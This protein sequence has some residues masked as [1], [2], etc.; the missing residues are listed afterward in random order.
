MLSRPTNWFAGQ[1]QL[2]PAADIPPPVPSESHPK[3]LG[4]ILFAPRLSKNSIPARGSLFCRIPWHHRQI[5]VPHAAGITSLLRVQHKKR[6]KIQNCKPH[7]TPPPL[8]PLGMGDD[9][10]TSLCDRRSSCHAMPRPSNPRQAPLRFSA[11][12]STPYHMQDPRSQRMKYDRGP[13]MK[14]TTPQPPQPTTSNYVHLAKPGRQHETSQKPVKFCAR[15]SW[16]SRSRSL[17]L[18]HDS[19]GR[20]GQQIR[21]SR[22]WPRGA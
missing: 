6:K 8:P 17:T 12:I 13:L 20:R 18:S 9:S 1:D 22:P 4:G 2:S 14:T 21:S 16:C 5:N 7:F 19:G 15:R 3:R 11:P 10:L